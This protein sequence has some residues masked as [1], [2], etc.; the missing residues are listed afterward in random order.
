MPADRRDFLGS[1]FAAGLLPGMVGHR[2]NPDSEPLN[3]IPQNSWDVSWTNR[4]TGKH[5]AVFDTPEISMGLGLVRSLIW[6][7]DYGEVYGAKPAEMSPVVVLRHNAIWL[8]MNDE[9]WAHHKIGELN[10]IMDPATKAP[11]RRNPVIGANPFGLPPLA[12]DSLKRALAAGTVWS[13]PLAMDGR[14]LG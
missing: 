7:K 11:I 1:L 9:F 4:I 10:K 6:V 3:P 5:R 14:D 8:I 2:G 12:D 13:L